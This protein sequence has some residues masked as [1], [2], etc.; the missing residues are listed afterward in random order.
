MPNA[1]GLIVKIQR[2]IPFRSL[3]R[4]TGLLGQ[5]LMRAF[6][7]LFPFAH[8]PLTIH[9]N[10][11][12]HVVLIALVY[13]FSQGELTASYNHTAHSSAAFC[14]YTMRSRPP[15]PDRKRRHA[16]GREKR[17]PIPRASAGSQQESKITFNHPF[18]PMSGGRKIIT[19]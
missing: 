9:M 8:H 7:T 2:S 6:T 4:C 19:L 5:L 15:S 1:E 13:V 12:H 14:C 16:E 3:V 18:S 17:P 11:V 10:Y